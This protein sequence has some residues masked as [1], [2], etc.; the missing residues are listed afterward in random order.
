MEAKYET[1]PYVTIS[2]CLSP[3]TC[4]L[5]TQLQSAA[6]LSAWQSPPAC[7]RR[8]IPRRPAQR[9]RRREHATALQVARAAHDEETPP[10]CVLSVL[11]ILPPSS[12][13][14]SSAVAAFS[15]QVADIHT[16]RHGRRLAPLHHR[17]TT[18]LGPRAH[19][20]RD[21]H[22]WRTLSLQLSQQQ[23]VRRRGAACLC[24][25]LCR[26]YPFCQEARCHL[27]RTALRCA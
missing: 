12:L 21:R 18:R 23:L 27:S 15:V 22:P 2:A 1:D 10:A 20:P 26:C 13:V 24:L 4:P 7:D 11:P 19:C 6:D 9:T 25:E 17:R 14:E 16:H 8:P 3:L 5:L